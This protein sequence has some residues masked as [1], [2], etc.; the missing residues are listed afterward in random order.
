MTSATLPRA[1]R[2]LGPIAGITRL[3]LRLRLALTAGVAA[4]L[5]VIA[6]M[7]MAYYV[8]CNRVQQTF[9]TPVPPETAPPRDMLDRVASLQTTLGWPFVVVSVGG[10]VVA[11]VLGWI[12]AR[13]ALSP[14]ADLTK[15]ARHVAETRDLKLRMTV[16]RDDELGSLA[17]SFNTMLD[18]LERSADAQRQLV[19]DASH[20]LRTPLAAL[21][22]NVELILHADRLDPADRADLNRAVIA[23]FEELTALVSDVVELARDEEPAALVEDVRFDHV[24]LHQ[25]ER[26]AAYWPDIRFRHD[27]EPM[28]VR[29]VADRLSRAVANLLDNAGKYAPPGTEVEVRLHR[30]ELTVRDHGPGIDPEDLPYIFD[31]FYRAPGARSRPGSG[32]GLAIVRQVVDTHGGHVSAEPAPGGGTLVRLTL[33]RARPTAQHRRRSVLHA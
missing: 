29:G 31:R 33:P 2:L 26:S 27:L 24:V 1:R 8:A 4:A 19:A 9:G 20:E 14:V 13:T 18:A 15:A 16:D 17:R 5:S 32:L 10:L 12:A 21:R 7:T 23:G 3:P 25:I 6:V 22:T 30:G 28:M 11:A